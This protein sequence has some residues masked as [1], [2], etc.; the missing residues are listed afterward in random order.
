MNKNSV[1]ENLLLY[2]N[3]QPGLNGNPFLRGQNFN[4]GES[5][6]K[7]DWEWKTEIA[8]QIIILLFE[9]QTCQNERS[10]SLCIVGTDLL[11]DVIFVAAIAVRFSA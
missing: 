1:N 11:V 4:L 3:P 6:C 7:K 10:G 2:G 8:A 5:F 9:F